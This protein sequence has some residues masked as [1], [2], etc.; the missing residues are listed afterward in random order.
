VW[1]QCFKCNGRMISGPMRKQ[2]ARQPS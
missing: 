1:F 2:T